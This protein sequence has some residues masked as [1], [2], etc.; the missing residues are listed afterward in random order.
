MTATSSFKVKENDSP[1][2]DGPLSSSKKILPDL[3]NTFPHQEYLEEH[4]A[5]GYRIVNPV[6]PRLLILNVENLGPHQTIIWDM[7][8]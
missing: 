6:K 3:R 7:S 8:Y 1:S 4:E 5:I 2:E